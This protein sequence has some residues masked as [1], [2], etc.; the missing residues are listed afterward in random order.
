M[1]RAGRPRMLKGTQASE[2]IA[3]RLTTTEMKAL[4]KARGIYSR[5]LW[6]RGML[7]RILGLETS[8]DYDLTK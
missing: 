8:N 1:T 7:R 6:L 2:K 3:L 4:D 5:S